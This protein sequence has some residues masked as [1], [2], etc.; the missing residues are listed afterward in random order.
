MIERAERDEWAQRFGVSSA[1]I[2]RDHFI[3]HVLYA[4]GERDP[5]TRFYGGTALCRT[6]LAQTRLSEDIDL[7][8]AEPREFLSALREQLPTALRREFPGTSAPE[9][10]A[11]GD[12]LASLLGP[13][14]LEPIKL[15]VGRDGSNTTAWEFTPTPVELRYSDLPVVQEFQCPTPPTFAAMK[16]AAWSDRHAPRDLFDL[17]GLAS[18]GTLTD[19][20]VQRIYHAKMGTGI[21]E[22]E[23]IRV[24]SSTATAWETELRAQVGT[25]PSAETCLEHVRAALSAQ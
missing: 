3:S 20:A 14:D 2:S 5:T 9:P 21:I 16:L 19:P 7:L 15:Y 4:L 24:P 6:Y 1:Q 25:L 17:D 11:E 23:F 8:H 18:R 13:P 10:F 22:A 12:G